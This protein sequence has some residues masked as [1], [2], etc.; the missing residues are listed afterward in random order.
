[1]I[2]NLEWAGFNH[3]EIGE[4]GPC[5]DAGPGHGHVLLRLAVTPTAP[6][7]MRPTRPQRTSSAKASPSSRRT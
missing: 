5:A 1:V 2:E 3:F 6:P 7:T 4:Q